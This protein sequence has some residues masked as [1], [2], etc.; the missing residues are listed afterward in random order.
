MNVKNV[1]DI[2]P[3]SPLQQAMLVRNLYAPESRISFEQSCDILNGNLRIPAFKRAW[4][5]VIQRHSVLRTLFLME[6]LDEPLQIVRQQIALPWEQHDWQGLSS[7]EQEKQLEILLQR[8]RSCGFELGKAPLMRLI[9]VQVARGTYY[10]IWSFHHIILDGWSRALVLKEV[11]S[12]YDAFRQNQDLHLACGRPYRDYIAWLQQQDLSKAEEYWR[13]LLRGFTSPTRLK[14]A[15]ASERVSSDERYEQQHVQLSVA[16]TAALQSLAQRYQITM[17][18]LVRGVWSLLLSH[19]SGEKDVVFGATVSGRPEALLGAESMVGMFINILPVRVRVSPE[20][21]LQSWLQELQAQQLD[22]HR[23]EHTPL[24]QIQQWSEVP[25][26]FP[27]F[28]SLLVF[29]NYPPVNTSS[30]ERDASLEMR[31]MHS[32]TRTNYP[33]TIVADP[34]EEL[35]LQI[36]YD[37]RRFDSYSIARMARHLQTLLESIATQPDIRLSE[38]PTQDIAGCPQ[39]SPAPHLASSNKLRSSDA[40]AL[41]GVSSRLEESLVAPETPLEFQL[42][43][44]WE[45]ILQI[46]PI[47]ITDNFF[48][49]GGQSI[50]ALRLI[51]Q[52][53]KQFGQKFPL[54]LLAQAGNIKQLAYLLEQQ[55]ILLSPSP[56]IALQPRGSKPPFFCVHPA[57]GNVLCYHKLAHYLSDDQPFFGLYDPDIYKE[58][59]PCTA[60]EEM[61]SRYIEAIRTVQPGGPYL[62]GGYSFGS[63][64]AFE[65]AQQLRKQGQQIAL[66]AILDGG[67]PA[68]SQGFADDDDAAFFAILTME[69][70]RGPTSKSLREVYYDLRRLELQEQISY[71]WEQMERAGLDLPAE[72]PPWVHHSMQIFKTRIQAIKRYSPEIYAGQITFFQSSEQHGVEELTPVDEGWQKFST[73]PMETYVV[74]GYHD[75][76]IDEPDVRTLAGYLQTC[77]DKALAV[78]SEAS[79][80]K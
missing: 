47:G 17:N 65:M 39:L 40:P 19:Y 7:V 76:I 13:A 75:T 54:S 69:L 73:K 42:V 31:N 9:L 18:I 53:Q 27:L 32:D 52:I 64:V 21:T 12:F 74:P 1:E 33:I 5:Q 79:A 55:H 72:G 66:L 6:G 25:W 67:S 34:G 50:L 77:I 62:L 10:F 38:L 4:Q 37:C 29:E 80:L 36:I 14:L 61:A 48:D 8:D 59:F 51:T 78:H 60:I 41:D 11:F 63:I 56:L 15:P 68:S 45:D 3:L 43:Q 30:L 71:V 35:G 16:T 70:T 28:E 26:N 57:S 46:H 58:E 24:V 2:Y 20:A 23:Y 22:L 44:I 49:L